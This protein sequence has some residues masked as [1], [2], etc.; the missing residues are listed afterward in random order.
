MT[1]DERLRDY[2]KRVTVD[3]HDTRLRLR[4][5]EEQAH[6][7]I[8]I[9][10]MSCRYPGGV[11]TPEQLWELVA[12]GR[13]AISGFPSDRGWDLESLYDP[14]PDNSR[15]SYA[16]EGGFLDDAG[17]FDPEFFGISPREALAMDPQQRLLLEA[18]WEAIEDAGIDPS[19]LHGSQTG[20]FAGMVYQGYA[21]DLRSAPRGLEHSVGPLSMGSTASVLSGRVAYTLGLKGPAVTL[22]TACSSSLVALHLACQ[23]LRG[24]E[25]SL[26]LAGGVAVMATPAMFV[27]FS[28]QRGLARDGRCKSFADAADGTGF[29]EGVGVLL[30]ERLS[31][32]RRQGH[33]VL[34]VVRGSAVN[35]DGASNG[36]TA[37]NGPSQQRVIAQALASARLSAGQVDVVEG[38]GTGTTLGDPIEAQALLA[39]YGQDRPPERP[40]W[41]GSIKSNIGHAQ[42]AAG[43]SG[44]I[45]MVMAM[46]HGELPK[47]LHVDEPSRQVDWSVGTVSLL[48][49]KLPWQS[50][51]EPR[52]AGVSSFGV[53]GTNAH[54]ILEEAAVPDPVVSPAASTVV[55]D[56]PVVGGGVVSGDGVLGGEGVLGGVVPWLLSGR[57]RKALCAQAERLRVRVAEDPEIKLE[58]VGFSLAVGRTTFEHRAVVS[59]HSREGLLDGLEVLAQGKPAAGVHSGLVS[60]GGERIALLFAGQGSQRV[61]MGRELYETSAVFAGE[62]DEVCAHLDPYLECSLRE[63]VFGGRG[64]SE[65]SA[66]ELLNHTMFAQAGLFALEVALFRLTE[67]L[68]VRPDCLMGHSIGELVAAYVAEMFSLEDACA[69]VAARGRLMGELPAGGAMVSVQAS[70]KEVRQ[71][72]V[73]YEG[74]VALAAVNG[75]RS[76]VFSGDEDAVLDLAGLWDA[77][78]RKTKRLRVSHAFHSPRMD[79][80]LAEFA[81]VAESVS[82]AAPRIPIVSNLTGEIA[83]AEERCSADYW[84][85]HVRETVR[86]SDGVSCLV[87]RG[88]GCF[89]ELGPDGVLSA[90]TRDCL[91]GGERDNGGGEGENEAGA[92]TVPALRGE[93]PEAQSLMSALAEIW[94]HGADVDWQAVLQGAGASQVKLPTYAFQR[95]RYWLE[96]RAIGVGDL[97]V[98][99]LGAAA[100]PLLGAV[101]GLA[102][103]EGWLF[104]GRLSL[105][106]HP[107][108]ADHEVMGT[109]LLPGTAFVELALRAGSEVGCEVLRELTLQAPLVLPAHG[110]VQ[111]QLLVGEPGED[112]Q[113]SVSIYSR[114]EDSAADGLFGDE[115]SWTSHAAGTLSPGARASGQRAGPEDPVVAGQ[116]QEL[117]GNAW[118]PAGSTPLEIGDLYEEMAE[119]GFAYGPA[120]QGLKAAWRRGEEVFAEV[121]LSDEQREEADLFGIHPA[122]LDAALHA[123]LVSLDERTDAPG[124]DDNARRVRLPFSWGGVGLFAAGASRLR[125]RLCPTSADGVSLLAVDEGGSPV[126]AVQSLVSREISEAQFG[127]AQVAYRESLFG[128]DWDVVAVA[129][130]PAVT[131]GE[132]VVLGAADP[133]LATAFAGI[134]IDDRV[135]EDLGSLGAAVDDGAVTPKVVFVDCAPERERIVGE[136]ALVDAGDVLGVAHADLYRVLRLTQ[137]WLADERFSAGRLVVLTRGAVAAGAGDGLTGLAQAPVWGLM[138]A[139]QSEHPGRIALVDIDT[140]EASRRVLS[141]ALAT[142]EPQI[143]IREG[144]VLAPRLARV[145]LPAP[146]GA[147]AEGSAGALDWRGTVLI[148]GGTGDLGRLVARHLV[149]VH[150]VPSVLLASRRGPQADGAPELQAELEAL[151]ACVRIATCDVTNRDELKRLLALV[152]EEFPLGGVVHAA[153]IIDD[154]VVESLTVEQMTRV[155]APKA[156]AAWF[157]HELTEHLGLSAFVMFS[158]AAGTLGNPGQGSYAAGNV[159]LD[160]LA[161]YRRS[162]G[163]AGI[164]MAWGMWAQSGGMTGD[165]GEADMT[166]MTRAGV[167]ALSYEEGMELFDLAPEM[168]EALAI[169]VRLDIAA[170][171]AQ[172]SAGMV[173]ALLRGLIRLPSPRAQSGGSLARRLAGVPED[174]R[175]PLVLEIVRAEVAS[176]LGHAS[177]AAIDERRAFQ[178]LGFDS[179]AAVELR[180]RLNAA[181][182]LQL[183][184]TLVFDYPTPVAVVDY[185]LSEVAGVRGETSAISVVAVDEPVAIVGMSCRYPGGVRS[186]QELWELVASGGDAIDRF[187]TNRGWDLDS[188]YDPDPDHA[189][190]SYSCEGGFLYDAGEFDAGFFGISPREA[191]AMDPQQRLLLEASWG[192]IEDAG[193]DPLSLRG[194]QT[195]V[196]SGVMYH[197]YGT[198]L[199]SIPEELEGYMGTGNAGSVASGRVAYTFGLEGPAVTVD[200]ACSSSL[201]ALHLACQALREGECSMALAGGV[202]VMASPGAFVE[203]SRQRGLAPDGRCKSFA[204]AANGA[205]WSE[206]VGVLLVER[207][208]DARRLGHEVLAVV[209][210]SAV[211]QDGASNGMTAPNGPSQQRVIGRALANA[212]LSARQVD[213]VEGHGTGTPLGDPIEAQALLATYG[214]DR[215]EG[216]P[217][218][219]GSIKSNIGHTQAAAGAAGVIKMVMAMR[220]GVL[221]RTLHVD[222]PARQVDWSAGGVS[223]LEEEVPWP[224]NGQP[225]RAGVSSFGIS[226]TNAHVILE[227]APVSDPALSVAE[228][229]ILGDDAAE[230]EVPARGVGGAVPWVLSGRGV[231]GLRSQAERLRACVAGDSELRLADVGFSLAVGRSA[232]EH[233]AV[234]FGGDAQNMLAGLGALAGGTPV[235]GVVEGALASR[236]H[237]VAFL[238]TGQGSQRVGMGREL[239]ESSSVF[240][241]ALDEVCEHLDAHL[242]R[243]LRGVLFGESESSEEGLLDGTMFAQAGLF[244]LGVALHRLLQAWGVRPDF[245]VGHSIGELTA[246]H[247]AGVFSLEDACRLVAARGRLMGSLPAGGVMVSVQASEEEVLQTLTGREGEVSLAAVNGPAA[248]V[249]SGGEDGVL[250]L[251]ALWQKQ[252]RKVKRL[253]VSHAFHSP[254]M[255]PMLEEFGEIARG[256]SFAAPRIPIVSNLTGEMAS[257]EELCS[258]DYWVRHVREPVRFLDGVRWLDAQ[259]VG[260]FLELGPD[261][262]LSAMCRDCLE[263]NGGAGNE[264]GYA[265]APALR[266]ERPEE[267]TLLAGVAAMWVRGADVDWGLVF[268]G[269]GAKRVRLPPY[270]FQ[271]DHYWL[272]PQMG[273]TNDAVAMGQAAADHPLLS[274]AVALA[275]GEGWLFTGRL[276]LDTHPWLA[277]HAVMGVVLL[278]GTAFVDLALRAGGEVGCNVVK[279]LTL[280]APLVLP[281]LGGVQLQLLV[282]TPDELGCRPVSIYARGEGASADDVW[283]EQL[284]WTRHAGGVLASSETATGTRPVPKEQAAA[285]AG[286]EW[287]PA[288]AD[289]LETGDLYDRLA[290]HGYHYGPVFQGLR[291][292][293]RRGEEVFAEVSLPEDEHA[294]AGRFGIH[295]ALL[296]AALHAISVSLEGD[297]STD[298]QND[299]RARL[300]FSWG[301]VELYAT[302]ASR[303]RVSLSKTG[304]DEMSLVMAD[305]SGALVAAVDSLVTREVSARQLEGVDR[306]RR[307]SLFCLEWVALSVAS[308]ANAGAGEVVL[309]TGGAGLAG[310]LARVGVDVAVYRDLGS[311]DAAVDGGAVVPEVVLVDCAPEEESGG[312][313]G[314]VEGA[315]EGV[316]VATGDVPGAAR[317]GVHRVLELMQAWLADERF[318]RSRLVLTTK[319]AAAVRDG[320]ALAGLEQ[321]PVWGLV[322]A[323]QSEHPGRFVLVDLDN[324]EA[325]LRRLSAVLTTDEPQIAIR[326]GVPLVARLARLRSAAHHGASTEDGTGDEAAGLGSP[327]TA[328]ITGGTG[329]LGGLFA[330]H[331]VA[332]HGVRSI[333]LASRRGGEAEGAAELRSE[334]EALGAQVTF[335][336]CDVAD[337]EQLEGTLEL[338]PEKH[339]LSVVVH[340][341][342]VIDDGVIDSLTVERVD[343]VL[344][345]KVDAAWHLHELTKD[346]DL[347]AFVLFSSASGTF[348]G[349]GQG[350]YAA[351]NVFL[352]ALA[353]YRRARGLAG[354]SLAWGI[355]EQAS[356]MTEHLEQADLTRM[357]RSGVSGLSSEEG[358][359]LFDAVLHA[360]E[361]LV[362]PIRLDLAPLRAQVKAGIVPPLLRGLVRVPA[363]DAST[364]A[365]GSL[366]RR[367]AG[368]PEVERESVV[369]EAVLGEAAIV[370]GHSSPDALDAQRAFLEL[371]FDSLA[372]VELRNRLASATGLQLPP[373]LVFD[374]ST[375]E[376]LAAHLGS[377]L[378]ALR[379]GGGGQSDLSNGG[380]PSREEETAGTMGSLLRQASD[381]GMV[382]KFMELL[383][384]AS[385]FRP[386]FAM[387]SDQAEALATVQLSEGAEPPALICFPSLLATSGPHQYAR[388]AKTFYGNRDVSVLPMPGFNRGECVP[389]SARVAIEA[390]AKAVQDKAGGSPF[391]LVGYSSS[392]VLVNAVTRYLEDVGVSPAAIVLIDPYSWGSSAMAEIQ[393]GLVGWMLEQDGQYLP[394]DDSRLTAMGAYLRLS[395]DWKPTEVAAPTLLLQAAEPMPGMSADGEWRSSWGPAHTAVDAPGDHFTMMEEHADAIAQAVQ[396]WLSLV[397]GPGPIPVET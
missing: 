9:V 6:E 212:G 343:R 133:P 395:A 377:Q 149:A 334:L 51:G 161:T 329:K 367:F 365:T 352:D 83:S 203:F 362:I 375:P 108:L 262:V 38:H 386:T 260:N 157:L 73:E 253:R 250:E 129:S 320:D 160:G 277:D 194:S 265:T 28:H 105:Q 319:E 132:W 20:V 369:L 18:S 66:V 251:A 139:A 351:A 16:R 390:L 117:A 159:F 342:G 140:E 142:D 213:V 217:L 382:D 125:V 53:S 259:G 309:G 245:V 353:A 120:F 43:V 244:A 224:Q 287:P 185:L 394:L 92:V 215:P 39:T 101:L 179:L 368:V 241:G 313:E 163:L 284:P 292:A 200:T 162:R 26:A 87:A 47:T 254:L 286:S 100:H 63:V 306:S 361:T 21:M 107:W 121:S 60:A 82:F 359:G 221:P 225:R 93:R 237:R 258:P 364:G 305:E 19:L 269:S 274:A 289:S 91:L 79:G 25:C 190:T 75:P 131:T 378:T 123:L 311:L 360:E 312:E 44:V 3:L 170:L 72:L 308:A 152:P 348:G 23:A 80:M 102:E 110:G 208:S 384:T 8:A 216:H 302:G 127:G 150:G 347:A 169:P 97:E 331:L 376:A 14:D 226:G 243:S 59:G 333:L 191:L 340:T 349:P 95:E 298:R 115:R 143:A 297:G 94:V 307:E 144:A 275:D 198:F 366:A 358:L 118:P 282:G 84:V 50:N 135:Y 187:P 36:L 318:S 122:L 279:E 229:T 209:R 42:A 316:E 303:L 24:G 174:E 338:V 154:G 197:D 70:E 81:K 103:G 112:G 182:G 304:V 86:F 64:L 325:S 204:D 238:F 219:L 76:V 17:E 328:L 15:T 261:G 202:T 57:S 267:Q 257:P 247:I 49:E 256:I 89:L 388:F 192:A 55:G 155:L 236:D 172:V 85:R 1:T 227:E 69:L 124:K 222:E 291:A 327:G 281:E 272:Q 195:G 114:I 393:S 119:K 383:L 158:S 109:V 106:T 33:E 389:E 65:D 177:P 205:G 233:R 392:G 396:D 137:E 201:V 27:G 111:V 211:N 228:S 336:K 381:Q 134:G 337:R 326:D 324:E 88:V 283:S 270:A 290:G 32:A 373:T 206:G 5:V 252:G 385:Q 239:Y 145:R 37:P 242:G 220:H 46:R 235:A 230:L 136:G 231:D 188:L 104:T 276:S 29:S 397:R 339:P 173:P 350:N 372:A 181:T 280:E 223:L 41:L 168:G 67:A 34:A 271:R 255:E 379:Q 31:D 218:W 90:M 344:A 315:P 12:S 178:E 99:G 214:R 153:G 296:D 345:P 189:G 299:G 180:N 199:R 210:G 246:A 148:T 147:A 374:H 186:A 370:L 175:E 248:V 363:R 58:D 332:E 330:R 61:G 249:L 266:R 387:P 30:L 346:L 128:L 164:S 48:R 263:V 130:A 98:A 156:D 273:G 193:I 167:V 293:W 141:A 357:E 62:F 391:A 301:G 323:A 356:G 78:G 146:Q 232:L 56:G 183:P 40:L 54:V 7:R 52:C 11:H 314:V 278:P 264:N 310:A 268:E 295:P 13:D 22:D 234:V 96:G 321:A 171:R 77:R 4:E 285:L 68:G 138:R 151:G 45:K 317:A 380:M 116:A 335:A 35:Q 126:A 288:G 322:R 354:L 341:A 240:A 166:R 2:L 113:R 294:R 355:W 74:R 10:G 196:F 371:G 71:T 300:P 176:V 165:L 207:L 184:A